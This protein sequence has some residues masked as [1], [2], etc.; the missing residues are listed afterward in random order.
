MSFLY[1]MG[2]LLKDFGEYVQ[3]T[4]AQLKEAS[5][6]I[7]ERLERS[8]IYLESSKTNKEQLA[9]KIM[10]KDK[11]TAGLICLLRCVE[12]CISYKTGWDND[13]KN[14]ILEAKPR[15]C[16]YIYHYWIDPDAQSRYSHF[17]SA[18]IQP[19]FPFTIYICTKPPIMILIGV[20]VRPNQYR[21]K[22]TMENGLP[23]WEKNLT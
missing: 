16:L 20:S 7:A 22:S 5:C 9:K 15:K 13:S 18:R 2:V 3:K 8:N 23:R 1:D 17:M 6:E 19:W 11:L 14:L 12:P 10:D 4:S 21:M